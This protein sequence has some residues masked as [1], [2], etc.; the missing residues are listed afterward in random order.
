MGRCKN[1]KSWGKNEC[2]T[3]CG[4]D[5]IRTC[6]MIEGDSQSMIIIGADDDYNL[7]CV[8]HE[9]FSCILFSEQGNNQS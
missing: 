7:S 2:D 3:W 4:E 1:C 5:N 6:H 9:N 8:T